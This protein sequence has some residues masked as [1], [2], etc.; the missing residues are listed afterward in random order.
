MGNM[1]IEDMTTDDK[2]LKTSDEQK[3]EARLEYLETFT[4][5]LP[6]WCPECQGELSTT[7]DEDETICQK[8][9]L[10]TSMSIEYV[11]G[12]KISLPYGRH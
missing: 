7:I 2:F 4:R 8:C 11:S 6:R 12:Q 9:G 5:P 3:K 1:L 10:I